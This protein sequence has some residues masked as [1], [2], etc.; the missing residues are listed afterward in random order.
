MATPSSILARIIPWTEEPGGLQ[1]MGSQSQTRLSTRTR[2]IVSLAADVDSLLEEIW[3][4]VCSSEE[5]WREPLQVCVGS[6]PASC[7]RLSSF[8]S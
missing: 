8:P 7:I 5:R 4:Q 3:S 2:C 1:P 6:R